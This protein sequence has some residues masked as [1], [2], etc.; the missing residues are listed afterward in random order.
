MVMMAELEGHGNDST[1]PFPSFP[2]SKYYRAGGGFGGEVL[3]PQWWLLRTP[4]V[5]HPPTHPQW[6]SREGNAPMDECAIILL[7]NPW[8]SRSR[9]HR[10]RPGYDYIVFSFISQRARSLIRCIPQRVP[11]G[12]RESGGRAR[13]ASSS[14]AL[15]RRAWR[16]AW[17][18]PALPGGERLDVDLAV[19]LH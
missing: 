1:A 4:L 8:L 3:T 10:P 19:A 13:A 11:L 15:P 17:R 2:F 18:G 12:D 5:S 6:R 7:E 14:V 16:R 9:S